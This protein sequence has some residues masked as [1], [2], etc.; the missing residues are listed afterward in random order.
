MATASTKDGEGVDPTRCF[1]ASPQTSGLVGEGWWWRRIGK[2]E[3]VV[4][5]AV[6]IVTTRVLGQMRLLLGV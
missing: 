3:R 4:T 1:V 5:V 2:T 6:F